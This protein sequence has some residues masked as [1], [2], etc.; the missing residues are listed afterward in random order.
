MKIYNYNQDQYFTNES[1]ASID[2]LETEKQ[3]KNVY[4]IP[5]N[6]TTVPVG[7]YD[8]STEIP[9]FNTQSKKWEIFLIGHFYKKIGGDKQV[10]I[11]KKDIDLYTSVVPNLM[12]DEMEDELIFDDVSGWGYV[13]V[14]DNTLEKVKQSKTIE[15]SDEKNVLQYRKF[16]YKDHE[17]KGTKNAR[18]NLVDALTIMFKKGIPDIEWLSLLG[19]VIVLDQEDISNMLLLLM[20]RDKKL[21]F[22]ESRMI[23]ELGKLTKISDIVNYEINFG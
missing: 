21:Y 18:D 17:F 20:E 9:R 8:K 3:G 14:S 2:L 5:K 13:T 6:A 12:F 1:E 10:N 23:L 15:I 22:N 7:N 19:E 16:T 11:L 4:L